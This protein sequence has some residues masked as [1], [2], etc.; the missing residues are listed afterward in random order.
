[1]PRRPR[2]ASGGRSWAV[3]VPRAV[4]HADRARQFLPFAALQGYY[5]LVRDRERVCEERREM[6]DELAEELSR[7]L[8]RLERG[9]V[10]TLTYYD[11]SAYVTT[12]GV[13]TAI[14]EVAR[15]LVVVRTPVSFDD[16]WD[17]EE[18]KG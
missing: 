9:E 5:D 12:T 13:L 4:P 6:G 8:A 17:V 18:G 11:G 1:M 3:T 15:R 10:V 14:D 7:K 2:R 16:L